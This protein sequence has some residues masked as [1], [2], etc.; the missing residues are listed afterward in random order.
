MAKQHDKD[1]EKRLNELLNKQQELRKKLKGI[2]KYYDFKEI[3]DEL[4]SVEE[5]LFENKVFETKDISTIHD[6][7][8]DSRN[9]EKIYYLFGF[10][11]EDEEER[12]ENYFSL[13]ELYL[14]HVPPFYK[15]K[16][17]VLYY[18][19]IGGIKIIKIEDREEFERE[20][21]VIIGKRPTI[22]YRNIG[23]YNSLMQ[24]HQAGYNEIMEDFVKYQRVFNHFSRQSNETTAAKQTYLKCGK[25]RILSKHR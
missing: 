14:M 3:V 12:Y 8:D 1:R 4:E 15:N 16:E 21:Y 19:L 20:N 23:E 17:Y 11:K 9:C 18:N 2:G 5:E 24:T 22:T 13:Y 10:L 25:K 7:L 6:D